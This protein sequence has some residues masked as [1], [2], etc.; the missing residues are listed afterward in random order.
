MAG[1]RRVVYCISV[2]FSTF[3]AFFNAEHGYR[4]AYYRSAYEGLAAND[5][6]ISAIAPELISWAQLNGCVELD[7]D[8]ESL[9]TPSAKAWLAE[10]GLRFCAK[11]E[12]EWTHPQDSRREIINGRWENAEDIRGR[13]APLQSKIRIFGAFL[14]DRLGEFVAER[15]RHRARQLHEVGWS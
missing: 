5:R 15:K 4:G 7:F 13:K 3:D 10:A 14:S 12:G 9:S 2:P 11:C 6:L 8:H 1:F